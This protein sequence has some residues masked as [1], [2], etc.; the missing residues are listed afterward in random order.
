MDVVYAMPGQPYRLFL[1]VVH[2]CPNACLFCVDFKGDMF[3][4]FDLKHGRWPT[5]QEIIAAVAAY[6][7]RQSV[8]EVYYCGIG[9]PLLL[10]NTV[11]ETVDDIRALFPSHTTI[12]INTS[13]TFYLRHPRVDFA[14]KFDLI[15]VSL[16][17][18]NEEKYNLICRP[19]VKGAYKALM[20]FLYDL[21]DFIDQSGIACRVELSVVDPF[22]VEYLP[23]QERLVPNTP[24]PDLDACLLI[25]DSFRWPLKVKKL[26]KDCEHEEWKEFAVSFRG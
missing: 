16:N 2:A 21:R 8:R 5:G 11:M 13:G 19:K 25:A 3:Y 4:G 24:R 7:S 12:A 15:Q 9:E 6:P 10:Y 22:D 1:N 14:R 18:E 20:A 17:A 23:A 26:I